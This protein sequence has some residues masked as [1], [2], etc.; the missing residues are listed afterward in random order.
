MTM[1]GEETE[2]TKVSATRVA[3]RGRGRPPRDYSDDPDLAVAEI[4][5]ALQAAWD[6]SER[7]AFDMALMACYGKPG[8][9][10]KLPRGARAGTWRGGGSAL[11]M[12]KGFH[13]RSADIRYKLKTGKL[14]PNAEI[15]LE[16]ARLLHRL[17]R[18]K[19]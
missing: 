13:S 8:P 14:S 7:K 16:M 18:R 15:V 19:V 6:L 10:T 3:R 4:A 12:G 5:I 17:R 2:M 11:P 1:P 9:L